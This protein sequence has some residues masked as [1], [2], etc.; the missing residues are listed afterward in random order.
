MNF[1]SRIHHT[2]NIIIPNVSHFC[3]C[4]YFEYTHMLSSTRENNWEW[5]II[6]I[7]KNC[8]K[9]AR[10]WKKSD[11]K[12]TLYMIPFIWNFRIGKKQS[13][14]T[15]NRSFVAW[16]ITL[17]PKRQKGTFGVAGNVLCVVCS[18]AYM[19]VYL[20]KLK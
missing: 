16:S 5:I 10:T 2:L 9:M 20:L 14:M 8:S 4:C 7:K 15:E 6:E 17:A 13:R 1:W 11:S 12:G 18:G 3:F 19:G